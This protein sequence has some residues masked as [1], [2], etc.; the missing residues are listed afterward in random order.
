VTPHARRLGP[1]I[2]DLRRGTRHASKAQT[3]HHS[4]DLVRRY[5]REANPF[6]ADNA[7]SLA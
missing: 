2:N 6:A 3:G 1:A 5:L 7:A 4:I